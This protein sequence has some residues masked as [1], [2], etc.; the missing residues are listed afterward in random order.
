MLQIDFK[1]MLFDRLGLG[2]DQE[3]INSIQKKL[4]ETKKRFLKEDIA[5]KKLPYEYES[6]KKDFEIADKALGDKDTIVIL[7][8]G[9]SD[10]G[11]RTVH[12][13]LN[14]KYHNRVSKRKIFF[15]GDTTD[16]ANISDTLDILDLKKTLF[17]VVSKSGKTIEETSLFIFLKNKYSENWQEHFLFLTDQITGTLREIATKEKVSAIDHLHDVGGRYSVLSN[18]GMVPAYLSGIKVE[19]ILRGARELDEM[20][21]NNEKELDEIL[22]YTGLLYLY[23]KGDKKI[24]VLM[25]YPNKLSAFARWYRQLFAESLGKKLNNDGEEVFEGITP[26][27][28][29]GPADQHSQLQLYNE[30]PNDKVITFIKARRSQKDLMTPSKSGIKDLEFLEDKSFQGILNLELGATAYSL[31]KNG[32]PNATII[33][34]ELDEYHLGQLLYMFEVVTVYLGYLLD[35]NPFD[36]PGVELSKNVIS[37]V[38]G[39]PDY[40][41]ERDEYLKLSAHA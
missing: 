36:Q 33:I 19:E 24:S 9:G 17:I 7:G 1:N 25:P 16:P 27:A 4:L 15:F 3:E 41:K 13:A 10:L 11:A 23:Y 8:I 35:V 22:T 20:I 38:L 12:S 2:V 34:P 39:H 30:G 29:I 28:A 6:L 5:F 32:R 26:I 31:L 18:V 21:K 14:H 37:G 40:E